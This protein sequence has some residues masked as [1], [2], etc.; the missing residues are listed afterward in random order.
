[1]QAASAL[2]LRVGCEGSSSSATHAAHPCICLHTFSN[3]T[4]PCSSTYVKFL[5]A[6]GCHAGHIR[7]EAEG[8]VPQL[9]PVCDLRCTPA[10]TPAAPAAE[11]LAP[12]TA[13]RSELGSEH[14]NAAAAL[15]AQ[16]APAAPS[17]VPDA[18]AGSEQ[19]AQ[20]VGA[21]S[22]AHGPD[23]GSAASEP[24]G[25]PGGLVLSWQAP[26]RCTRCEVWARQDPGPPDLP[27]VA[28]ADGGLDRPDAPGSGPASAA[29]LG[30][31]R[32]MHAGGDYTRR[33]TECE[34]SER[35]HAN[36]PHEEGPGGHEQPNRPD[37]GGDLAGGT[38]PGVHD[39]VSYDGWTWVGTS[40][41]QR[42]WLAS[43]LLDP[44]DL[45]VELAVQALDGAGRALPLSACPRVRAAVT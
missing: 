1:M 29:D 31:H 22:H 38:R 33:L 42:F 25:G 7:V 39:S 21:G 40:H 43:T 32:T 16:A 30:Q 24:H 44:G 37:A 34:H 27:A 14:A 2:K 5:T 18:A 23:H 15:H 35:L 9:L 17:Q 45:G 36:R 11:S 20:Q 4:P 8:P 41:A 28:A 13:G 3:A 26:K 12:S 6:I 19:G 10:H